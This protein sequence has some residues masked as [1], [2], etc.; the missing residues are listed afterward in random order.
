MT[1]GGAVYSW[2]ANNLGQL[3]IEASTGAAANRGNVLMPT[4]VLDGANQNGH[5]KDGVDYIYV[6][7]SISAGYTHGAVV[8]YEGYALGWGDNGR[9]QLGDF[10]TVQKNSPIKIG[11]EE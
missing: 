10:T 6:V 5:T 7:Q 1:Q 3:G 8:N 11:T 9:A 4:P 2:G